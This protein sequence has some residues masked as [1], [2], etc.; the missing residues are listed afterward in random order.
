[1]FIDN[2]SGCS[3]PGNCGFLLQD[4]HSQRLSPLVPQSPFHLPVLY[5]INTQRIQIVVTVLECSTWSPHHHMCV[6]FF[7]CYF[8]T[9]SQ[10]SGAQGAQV[11]A[12]HLIEIPSGWKVYVDSWFQKAQS[13]RPSRRQ[14]HS[15]HSKDHVYGR[16]YIHHGV[17]QKW[18][19]KQ[20]KRTESN[21]KRLLPVW[22]TSLS[23][24]PYPR[25][26]RAF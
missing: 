10:G 21:L 18:S 7:L 24:T 2:W 4:V 8:T 12:K 22:P 3:Q 5:P 20:E 25:G 15:D 23:W 19:T 26:S 16:R 6:L 1:V 11:E 13:S 9:H 14:S 17:P